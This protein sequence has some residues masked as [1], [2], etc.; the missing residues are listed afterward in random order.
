MY[1]FYNL[2]LALVAIAFVSGDLSCPLA[3]KYHARTSNGRCVRMEM[4]DTRLIK[5]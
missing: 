3:S 5:V 2:V 1:L 4:V